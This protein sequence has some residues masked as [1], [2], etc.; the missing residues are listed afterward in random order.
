[1]HRAIETTLSALPDSQFICSPNSELIKSPEQAT[2]GSSS[3]Q[4]L[5]ICSLLKHETFFHSCRSQTVLWMSGPWSPVSASR[6]WWPESCEHQGTKQ[7]AISQ[8]WLSDAAQM[9]SD[10]TKIHSF[11]IL[12]YFFEA[13][14]WELKA[15]ALLLLLP[16][17]AFKVPFKSGVFLYHH[18]MENERSGPCL[19]FLSKKNQTRGEK[20]KSHSRN[21]ANSWT[22]LSTLTTEGSP[23]PPAMLPD[24]CLCDL[25]FVLWFKECFGFTCD[26]SSLQPPP[27]LLSQ[28]R[29]KGHSSSKTHPGTQ[30]IDL[31]G[32]QT[33]TQDHRGISVSCT[34]SINLFCLIFLPGARP[35]SPQGRE[36]TDLILHTPTGPQTDLKSLI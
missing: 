36:N 20:K 30:R 12:K 11:Q 13:F 34:A 24:N 3:W 4:T 1:M 23:P 6:N 2:L 22:C 27:L 16:R 8:G 31:V 14:A 18:N 17:G 5:N 15:R 10:H 26:T 7:A 32:L 19:Y 35:S 28:T 29:Q 25:S 21:Q 9:G 33:E